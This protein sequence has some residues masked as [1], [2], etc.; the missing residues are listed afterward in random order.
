MVSDGLCLVSNTLVAALFAYL[1]M[2]IFTTHSSRKNCFADKNV[3][4]FLFFSSFPVEKKTLACSLEE[5]AC[6]CK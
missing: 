2:Y 1:L 4:F 6:A 5:C 3:R